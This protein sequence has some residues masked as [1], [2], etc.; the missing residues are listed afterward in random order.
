MDAVPPAPQKLYP[1]LALLLLTTLNLLNYVDRSVLFA[2]QPLVQTEFHLSNTQVGWLTSAFLLFYM[3]A[4][5]FAGPLA[6]RF[7][8]RAIIG[9]GAIFWSALTLMTAVTHSFSG[10][11]GAAHTGGNR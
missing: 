8:R 5:P 10:A 11:A 1:R 9:W 2:V 3:L 4:A 7:S 6:S